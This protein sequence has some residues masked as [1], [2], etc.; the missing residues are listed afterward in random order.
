MKVLILYYIS[1]YSILLFSESTCHRISSS[2]S[3]DFDYGTDDD[4]GDGLIMDVSMP[5]LAARK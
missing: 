2:S 1:L 5:Q 3:H 4:T